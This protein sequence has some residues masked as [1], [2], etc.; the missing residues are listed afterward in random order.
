[1]LATQLSHRV[2]AALDGLAREPW[3]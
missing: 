1:M 2:E 3:R